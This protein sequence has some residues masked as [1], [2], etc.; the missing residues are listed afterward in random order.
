MRN[1]PP[2]PF[3]PFL[4]LVSPEGNIIQYRRGDI[5][6]KEAEIPYIIPTDG[7]YTL[8]ATT[9]SS[10]DRGSYSLSFRLISSVN[11]TNVEKV[12]KNLSITGSGFESGARVLVNDVDYKGIEITPTNLM[13]K[14]AAKGIAFPAR[15]QVRLPDGSES[16][17]YIY[18]PTAAAVESSI[19]K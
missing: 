19:R 17:Q 7:T 14:K 15:V 5:I 8:E 18:N 9:T 4:I 1:K 3:I 13:G 11:I 10:S 16:N 12:G 6:N 2:S